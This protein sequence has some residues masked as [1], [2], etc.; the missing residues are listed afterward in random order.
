M[1]ATFV[2][3]IALFDSQVMS[4]DA[5]FPHLTMIDVKWRAFFYRTAV[6]V[7]CVECDCRSTTVSDEKDSGTC[8]LIVSRTFLWR[9]RRTFSIFLIRIP[10]S[11]YVTTSSNV[12]TNQ[13]DKSSTL[14]I[15]C[16]HWLTLITVGQ[17]AMSTRRIHADHCQIYDHVINRTDPT[18]HKSA[19]STEPH[20][21]L[22]QYKVW[23]DLSTDDIFKNVHMF[24]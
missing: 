15:R 6:R 17:C 19:T 12:I 1:K 21:T 3:K 16:I 8:A 13:Y 10:L 2:K 4:V 9:K 24:A 23:N 7:W 20:W 14:S 22:K 11:Q 5:G 18:N